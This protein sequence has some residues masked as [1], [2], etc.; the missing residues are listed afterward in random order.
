MRRRKVPSLPTVSR[1]CPP[2]SSLRKG[3]AALRY[4]ALSTVLVVAV[5]V[6]VAGWALR[7]RLRIQVGEGRGSGPPKPQ[8][9]STAR[10]QS[11]LGGDAP[12][13][14]AALPEC[15]EQLTTDTGPRAFLLAHLP[16]NSVVVVPPARLRYADCT[17]FVRDDEAVVSRGSDRLRIPPPAR[18]YR[19]PGTLS[20]LRSTAGG[21]ELRVYQPRQ[22]SYP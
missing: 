15:F 21:G 4:L 9:S 14:L 8:A 22:A 7:D 3:T 20:L 13:A 17:I 12:W 1:R 10:P 5:A 19:S 16:A 6:I 2:A 11:G 18:F